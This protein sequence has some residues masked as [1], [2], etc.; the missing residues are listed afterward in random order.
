MRRLKAWA[1]ALC[2]VAL[3][4]GAAA[5]D[6][7]AL[8][9]RT[10]SSFRGSISRMGAFPSAPIRTAPRVLW[11]VDLP[12]PNRSSIAVAYGLAYTGNEAGILYALNALTGE[13]VWRFEAGGSLVSTPHVADG[14][15]TVGSLDDHV[16]QLDARTG[17]LLWSFET[18]GDVYSSPSSDM[19]CT[20][21]RIFV[22][23]RDGNLYALDADDGTERWRYAM[24]GEIW[25]SP[26][27]DS[28]GLY[29]TSRSGRVA[30]FDVD[31]L[32]PLWTFDAGEGIDATPAVGGSDRRRLFVGDYGGD[33]H[34]LD[35]ETGD[36]LWQIHMESPIYG[37]AAFGARYVVINDYQGTVLMLDQVTGAEVWR[38]EIGG[39]AYSSP[40]ISIDPNG[41]EQVVYVATEFEGALHA[42]NASDGA[43]LWRVQTGA[44]GDWR[45]STPVIIG[46]TLFIG[47]DTRGVIAYVS[48]EE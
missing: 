24:G 41:V 47:S 42:L 36:L 7:D 16:Y 32:E 34:A 15:L 11:E 3:A 22:G 2:I 4:G 43:P 26:A 38:A 10:D 13:E 21:R 18:G 5:Q 33:F 9:D 46:D 35:A 29:A 19:C 48:D 25:A 27:T 6:G 20:T 40:S 37:S 31:T 14:R 8:R 39:P 17:A 45:S 23:S 30:A 28:S 1:L 44:Q 12:R